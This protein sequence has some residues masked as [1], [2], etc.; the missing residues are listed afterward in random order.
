MAI[1]YK[2]NH[3]TVTEEEF[4]RFRCQGEPGMGRVAP[5]GNWP[6][7]SWALGC[8]RHQIPEM[9]AAYARAGI[10]TDFDPATGDMKLTGRQHRNAIL[11]LWGKHDLD[12]GYGDE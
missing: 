10:P 6:K 1:I 4:R 2:I 12:G 11:T 5:A 9:R 3:R 7:K 8:P